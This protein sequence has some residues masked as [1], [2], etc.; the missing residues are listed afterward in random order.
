M[1]AGTL[2]LAASRYRLSLA[3]VVQEEMS[4]WNEHARGI[5][6]PQLRALA[7]SKLEAEGFNARAAGM[8]A[9]FA[10]R[11]RRRGIV[12]TIVAL[13]VLFDYLDG[14]TEP[15]GEGDPLAWRMGLFAVFNW[16][17]SE[18]S[19]DCEQLV[20]PDVADG[21]YLA[22]LARAVRDGLRELPSADSVHAAMSPAAARATQA[23]VRKHALGELGEGQLR[24]WAE[25][26]AV[27]SGF[28]W[29]E[30]LAGACASVLAI[31]ALIVAGSEPSSSAWAAESID[32]L[33]LAIG[34]LA[35]LLDEL[36][37]HDA[38]DDGNFGL[39]REPAELEHSLARLTEATAVQARHS[40]HPRRD[41]AILAG[42]LGYY[43]TAPGARTAFAAP[44]AAQL[45]DQHVWI[46]P[47]CVLMGAWRALESRGRRAS[48]RQA[49]PRA[50]IDLGH[51]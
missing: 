36:V 1:V 9:T 7:L 28:E 38:E 12:R 10:P 17:V 34:A 49:L 43:A 11:G 3:G 19:V 35:A 2:V 20:V 33:Y 22:A 47:A 6:D 23:Q 21:A 42:V 40:Q 45:R 31:H 14:R 41:L 29:R 48:R 51:R 27:G 25:E 39:R 16:A 13:E 5:A 26:A 18:P 44:I 8:L 32:R 37:D 30:Y 4:R 50:E 46:G 24:S 15:P